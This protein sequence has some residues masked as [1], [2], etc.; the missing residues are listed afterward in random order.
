METEQH[1]FANF[2]ADY[3]S[4]RIVNSTFIASGDTIIDGVTLGKGAQYSR[5]ENINGFYALR[6]HASYGKPIKPL[7]L[8]INFNTGL[9]HTHDVGFLNRE[10]TWSNSYGIN[11]GISRSEERRVGKECGSTCRSRLLPSH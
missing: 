9:S 8:N 3:V 5:P 1:L 7:K 11:Q 10:S 6:S 2:S 4:N